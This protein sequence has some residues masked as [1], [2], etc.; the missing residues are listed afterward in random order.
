VTAFNTFVVGAT[1]DDVTLSQQPV[2][3][4][5]DTLEP[6]ELDENTTPCQQEIANDIVGNVAPSHPVTRIVESPGY[7]ALNDESTTCA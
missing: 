4:I 6:I 5:I 3:R 1:D 7:I 2:T